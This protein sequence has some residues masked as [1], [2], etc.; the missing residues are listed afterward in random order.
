MTTA[1]TSTVQRGDRVA[2]INIEN[3]SQQHSVIPQDREIRLSEQQKN[4]LSSLVNSSTASKGCILRASILLHL[5]KKESKYSIV[6][7]LSTSYPTINKWLKRWIEVEKEINKIEKKGSTEQLKKAIVVALK[8][9][10]RSG[11]KP[12]FQPEQVCN[13]I[14]LACINPFDLGLPYTHWSSRLLA[15]EAI[16]QGIVSTISHGQ[17]ANFLKSGGVE[18]T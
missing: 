3:T 5:A 10:Y 8:D 2:N 17:V 1:D 11:N 9:S 13:I 6:S 4:I 7:Q 18:T 12:T 15:Q 14:A 16:K